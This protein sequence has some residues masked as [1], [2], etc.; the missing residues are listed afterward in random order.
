MEHIE[1][2]KKTLGDVLSINNTAWVNGETRLF[3]DLN[4]DSTASLELIVA[5][6]DEIPGLTVDP[7]TLEISHFQTVNSLVNYVKQNTLEQ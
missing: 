3:E 5:L 4:L 7:E 1:I 2:I 6:E